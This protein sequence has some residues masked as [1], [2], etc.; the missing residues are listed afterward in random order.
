M[1][2][3]FLCFISPAEFEAVFRQNIDGEGPRLQQGSLP[4]GNRL[5]HRFKYI[6]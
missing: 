2:E 5:F 6:Q 3:A 1:A 4:G